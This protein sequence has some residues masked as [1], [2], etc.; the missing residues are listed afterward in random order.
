MSRNSRVS[1]KRRMKLFKQVASESSRR[2]VS[3]LLCE[4]PPLVAH[5][6]SLVAGELV[7]DLLHLFDG[8]EVAD[9]ERGTEGLAGLHRSAADLL[10]HADV[11]A[12]VAPRLVHDA[13][14]QGHTGE[15]GAVFPGFGVADVVGADHALREV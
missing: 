2:R 12:L 14:V 10:D 11:A 1:A 3:R 13:G 9:D 7:V 4:L 6:Q 5:L 8:V 15:P